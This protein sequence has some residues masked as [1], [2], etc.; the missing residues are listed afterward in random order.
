VKRAYILTRFEAWD[1]AVAD[2]RKA[3]ELDFHLAD[4]HN[5][6]AWYQAEKLGINLKECTSEAE[7]ATNLATG[8]QE[9][10][11]H[12]DTLGWVWYKRGDLE[13]ARDYLRQAVELSPLDLVIRSHLKEVEGEL[14][15]QGSP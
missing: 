5:G 4:A 10:G 7:L 9:R 1:D 12:L 6:V 3:I 11:N 13:R 14:A 15:A 8:T 2:Y